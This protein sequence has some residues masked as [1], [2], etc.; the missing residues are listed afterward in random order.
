MPFPLP[1]LHRLVIPGNLLLTIYQSSFLEF[2]PTLIIHEL[3]Y[4]VGQFGI[5]CAF[6]W[7]R[8][9]ATKHAKEEEKKECEKSVSGKYCIT[10]TNLS[11]IL[12]LW[13]TGYVCPSE[14]YLGD[15]LFHWCRYQR[16]RSGTIQS[17][18]IGKFSPSRTKTWSKLWWKLPWAVIINF[19]TLTFFH[20]DPSSYSP[21]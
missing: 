15:M 14:G 17:S 8:T 21:W 16:Q 4:K 13:L 1:C 20:V 19:V 2:P 11:A 3:N 12:Y 9:P 7:G 10:L 5:N 18:T 6:Q